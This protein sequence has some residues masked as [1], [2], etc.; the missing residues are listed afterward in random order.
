M[1]SLISFSFEISIGYISQYLKIAEN[2]QRKYWRLGYNAI[3]FRDYS[4]K[5]IFTPQK[6]YIFV[7][8]CA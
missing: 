3:G 5:N 4:T 6:H 8:T 1:F 7:V 2:K